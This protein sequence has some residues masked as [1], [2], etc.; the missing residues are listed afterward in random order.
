MKKD[1]Y[2]EI[3]KPN[4][5]VRTSLSYKMI[6]DLLN[7]KETPLYIRLKLYFGILQRYRKELFMLNGWLAQRFDVSIYQVKYH[8]KKLKE[9]GTIKIENEGTFRRKIV[10]LEYIIIEEDKLDEEVRRQQE[11]MRQLAFGKSRVKDNVFL[12]QEELFELQNL[13]KTEY[14]KYIRQ[15]DEYIS[16]T[17][18]QYKSHYETLKAWWWKNQKAKEQKKKQEDNPQCL[19]ED[20]ESLWV[21]DDTPSQEDTYLGRSFEE[22]FG[23]YEDYMNERGIY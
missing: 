8:L 16:K 12:S 5:K 22:I 21:E 14:A 17:G 11:D 19:G 6:S 23:D 10:L 20:W 4:Q 13:M 18:K 7:N 3:I 9:D 2:Q 15:L 1:S